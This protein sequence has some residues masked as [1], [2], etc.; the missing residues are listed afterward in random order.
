M[1]LCLLQSWGQGSASQKHKGH[2]WERVG[3]QVGVGKSGD[4]CGFGMSQADGV[5]P[6][7]P[8]AFGVC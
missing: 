6:G 5:F 3:S 2:E 4:V 7:V 8:A 1:G